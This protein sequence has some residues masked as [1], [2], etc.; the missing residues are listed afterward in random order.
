MT[1]HYMTIAK[2]RNCVL[3]DPVHHAVSEA[4]NLSAIDLDATCELAEL[5]PTNVRTAYYPDLSLI[6]I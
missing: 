2:F 4:L 1:S 5:F 3:E 6:H